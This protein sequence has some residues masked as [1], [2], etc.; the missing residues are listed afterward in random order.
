[1]TAIFAMND[2]MA[3]GV[4]AY[5][6][7]HAIGVPEAVSVIGFDNRES[8]RYFVPQLTTMALPL[9][10]LGELGAESAIALVEGRSPSERGVRLPGQLVVRQSVRTLG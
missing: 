6:R 9:H 4:M 10:R 8:S 1:V 3:L 7:E 5:C 2:L